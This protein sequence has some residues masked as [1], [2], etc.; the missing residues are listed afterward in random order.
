MIDY[1]ECRQSQI[2]FTESYSN[3]INVLCSNRTNNLSFSIFI[4]EINCNKLCAWTFNIYIHEIYYHIC[5]WTTLTFFPTPKVIIQINIILYFPFSQQ[6]NERT[7]LFR[8]YFTNIALHSILRFAYAKYIQKH[9][10]TNTHIYTMVQPLYVD[11]DNLRPYS[12]SHPM[13]LSNIQYKTM[14]WYKGDTFIY[15]YI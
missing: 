12:R 14:R 11:I 1:F 5:I 9:A 4:A 10:H 6:T 3:S 8:A 2:K 7:K 13:S 15:I